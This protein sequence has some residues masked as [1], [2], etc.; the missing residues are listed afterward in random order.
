MQLQNTSS[1]DLQPFIYVFENNLSEK[2]VLTDSFCVWIFRQNKQF[3]FE[4]SHTRL[5]Y[6]YSNFHKGYIVENFW[7]A[8]SEEW[9]FWNIKTMLVIR[10]F[11]KLF[12]FLKKT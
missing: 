1:G 12:K 11:E 5:S 4:R 7:T 10:N 6:N 8:A 9:D 3:Y 2:L